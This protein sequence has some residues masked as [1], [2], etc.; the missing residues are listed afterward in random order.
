MV[1]AAVP[2]RDL[3]PRSQ[4]TR[5]RADDHEHPHERANRYREDPGVDYLLP[6][7]MGVY[8]GVLPEP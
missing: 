1:E 8:L 7:W 6:Y 2:A 5:L 3:G 4:L